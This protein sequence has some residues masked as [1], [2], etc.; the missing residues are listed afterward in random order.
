LRTRLHPIKAGEILLLEGYPIELRPVYDILAG[1][2]LDKYKVDLKTI[3]TPLEGKAK[4]RFL[5]EIR[6]WEEVCREDAG[7][8]IMPIYGTIADPLRPPPYARPTLVIPHTSSGQRNLI[9]YCHSSRDVSLLRIVCLLPY[10]NESYDDCVLRSK[11]LQR[12]FESCTG[13][14]LNLEL[15]MATYVV[16]A[17]GLV[18]RGNHS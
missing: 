18:Y 4:M 3:R 11:G 17:Y 12:G 5:R 10:F 1:E 2:Y 14:M 9:K 16:A 8:H 15:S 13:G 6:V 7:K